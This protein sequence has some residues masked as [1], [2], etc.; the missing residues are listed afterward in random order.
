MTIWVADKDEVLG[1]VAAAGSVSDILILT[2][3]CRWTL[4]MRVW[5]GVMVGHWLTVDE[6]GLLYD[7]AG[8]AVPR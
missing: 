2:W 3:R 5:M 8:V 1:A 6:V 4:R 7:T